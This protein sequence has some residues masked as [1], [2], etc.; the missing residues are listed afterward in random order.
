MKKKTSAPLTAQQRK[1]LRHKEENKR[2][3]LN[4][5]KPELTPEQIAAKAKKKKTLTIIII[6]ISLGVILIATAIILP[7][8]LLRETSKYPQAVINLSNGEKIEFEIWE[9]SCPIAATNFIFLAKA[10]F[11]NDTIIFDVQQNYVG[12]EKE[13]NLSRNYMRFGAYTNYN[14]ADRRDKNKDYIAEIKGFDNLKVDIRNDYRKYSDKRE[15]L[16]GYRLLKDSGTDTS[17][18]GEKG[19]ISYVSNTGADF[20][21]NMKQSATKFF[22][23]NDVYE[24][25][26]NGTDL[27]SYVRAFGRVTDEKSLKVIT[28]ILNMQ[29]NKNTNKNLVGTTP[30]IKI[31]NVKISNLNGYKWNKFDFTAFMNTADNGSTAWSGWNTVS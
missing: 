4:E 14:E 26:G 9:E 27:T 21:I 13:E 24:P 25:T 23:H 1:E 18:F 15:N 31:K 8:V 12:E 11:F 10:G 16:F 28:D 22:S 3:A 30:V 20:M 7:I 2:K 17:R 29:K 5:P 19:V 6:S